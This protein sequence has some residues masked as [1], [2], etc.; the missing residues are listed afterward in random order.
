MNRNDYDAPRVFVILQAARDTLGEGVV[1]ADDDTACGFSQFP[2]PSEHSRTVRTEGG[3]GG[4]RVFR[5]VSLNVS[6]AD[7]KSGVDPVS[8]GTDSAL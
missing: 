3:W 2:F 8:G 6:S 5:F 1:V 7:T 4:V